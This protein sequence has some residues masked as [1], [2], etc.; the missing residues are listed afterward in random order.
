MFI[1]YDQALSCEAHLDNDTSEPPEWCILHH[2]LFALLLLQIQLQSTCHYQ[3][4]LLSKFKYPEIS[5]LEDIKSMSI[6]K[7]LPP[8]RRLAS[9]IQFFQQFVRFPM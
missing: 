6:A 2:Q 8:D 5:A 4:R 7:V 9:T 3:R 1:V